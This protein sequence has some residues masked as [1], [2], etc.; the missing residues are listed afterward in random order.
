MCMLVVSFAKTLTPFLTILPARHALFHKSSGKAFNVFA[1][2][3][4]VL[5]QIT[6]D[7]ENLTRK[8]F[9]LLF[10]LFLQGRF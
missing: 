3:I 5:A 10:F 4:S 7:Y 1:L 9:C 2:R 6:I 8:I